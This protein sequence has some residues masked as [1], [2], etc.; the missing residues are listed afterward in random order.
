MAIG[1]ILTQADINSIKKMSEK[2]FTQRGYLAPTVFKVAGSP[3]A[4]NY[5]STL[6][7][8]V[9]KNK[10][11]HGIASGKNVAPAGTI[12][13]NTSSSA[14]LGINVDFF[15]HDPIKET[16]APVDYLFV[17]SNFLKFY[18][19]CRIYQT[20]GAGPY[21]IILDT[22]NMGLAATATAKVSKAKLAALDS[23]HRQLQ[24][25]KSK[26]NT[27][28]A[29]L[30][31]QSTKN[32]SGRDQQKFN[33][34]LL[35]L[36]NYE[37]EL[38]AI[39]GVDITF[40]ANGKVSGIGFVPIIWIVVIIAGAILAAYSTDKIIGIVEKIKV[41]NGAYD[42]Q[43]F[44]S[45]QSLE[46]DKA[47][48]AGLITPEQAAAERQRLQEAAAAAQQTASDASKPSTGLF[49]RVENL[50]FFGGLIFLGAKLIK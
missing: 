18:Y 41:L 44:S 12:Q 3:K 20:N 22:S 45:T 8:A 31:T 32:L 34:G 6:Q 47:E 11:I 28:A 10:F 30:Q 7:Q 9:L 29:Y 48:K 1:E 49:D 36:N 35:T 33:E 42:M 17:R 26:Y 5:Y 24:V 23:L 40:S 37:R 43:K 14:T 46:I 27:L 16:T 38:R 21:F 15:L 19:I 2:N 50:L 39:Q 4:F 13:L 25:A